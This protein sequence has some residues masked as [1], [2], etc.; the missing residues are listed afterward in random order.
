VTDDTPRSSVDVRRARNTTELDRWIQ[1][2]VYEQYAIT[3]RQLRAL[4]RPRPRWLPRRIWNRLIR[5][6]IVLEEKEVR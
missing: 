6:L 5:A 3:E 2:A 4:L 1:R